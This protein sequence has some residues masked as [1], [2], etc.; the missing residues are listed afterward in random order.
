[1]DEEEQGGTGET[2]FTWRMEID[3]YWI[4]AEQYDGRYTALNGSAFTFCI[5][6]A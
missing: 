2:R 4:I 6:E 1:V 3:G 5:S